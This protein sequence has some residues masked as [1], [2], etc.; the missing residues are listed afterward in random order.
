M[1]IDVFWMKS[2][3]FDQIRFDSHLATPYYC[4]PMSDTPLDNVLPRQIDPRKF[5][6]QGI[7]IS[8]KFELKQLER[9]CPLLAADEGEVQADLIFGIDDQGIRH[10]SG[11][12][13]ADVMMVCQRCLE[14]APQSVKARLNL[15]MVWSDEEASHLSK[16]WDPWIVGEGQLDL[17]QAIEDELILNLP[18]VAYH[19]YA[20]VP[21]TL[22]SI[23]SDVEN[24]TGN[25]TESHNA[26]TGSAAKQ[27]NVEKPNPFQ[28]LEQLKGT[29][30]TKPDKD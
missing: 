6:Q 20:C 5:A 26:V 21:Q 25:S 1:D 17:Y 14:P 18:I 27:Q 15:G 7:A 2:S 28:V 22:Y 29:L 12:V 3:T 11:D 13:S 30:A 9:I 16:S 4:A 8:G 10:L 19:Q 24:S 23:G